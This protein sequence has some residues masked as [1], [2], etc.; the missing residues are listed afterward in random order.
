MTYSEMLEQVKKREAMA[1]EQEAQDRKA[2]KIYAGF[3]DEARAL[4]SPRSASAALQEL[5]RKNA[6]LARENFQLR[7]RSRIAEQKMEALQSTF[8][9][10]IQAVIA[11]KME[12]LTQRMDEMMHQFA[13]PRTFVD[14]GSI[15]V[16]RT[17]AEPEA[18][19]V[20]YRTD[21]QPSA[22][23]VE[24]VIEKRRERGLCICPVEQVINV[25]C[26]CGGK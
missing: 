7:E 12:R 15:Q 22:S 10:N 26:T 20:F 8:M 1:R 11:A 23:L 18:E 16:Y 24:D 2:G 6:D 21:A 14:K 17:K 4:S 13:N 19:E 25:G 3:D 5:K 9:D